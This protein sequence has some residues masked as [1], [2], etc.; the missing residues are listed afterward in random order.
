MT[1]THAASKLNSD[2]YFDLIRALPLR[3]IRTDSELDLAVA[4]IDSLI[5][6]EELDPDEQDYLDVLAD[7][8]EKYESEQHPLPAVS[9]ADMLRHLIEAR[10]ITQLKLSTDTGIVESTISNILSGKRA[11][12]RKHITAFASYFKVNPSVFIS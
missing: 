12:S 1:T 6:R 7:Q 2:R 11:M 3:P 5:D 4:M 10:G 8:V 9:E